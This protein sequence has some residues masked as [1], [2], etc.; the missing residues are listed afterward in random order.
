MAGQ[1][2][3]LAGDLGVR[4]T[5][6]AMRVM[7]QTGP[8]GTGAYLLGHQPSCRDAH[9]VDLWL[10]LLFVPVVPLSRWCVTLTSGDRPELGAVDL[11]VHSRARIPTR[12][13]LLRAVRAVGTAVLASTPLAFSVLEVGSGWA[14]AVLKVLGG[15]LL[16]AEVIGKLGTA[17]E[18]GTMLAGVAAPILLLMRLDERTPRVSLR[19]ALRRRAP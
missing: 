17:W 6:V 8:V 13:A 1:R 5:R 10:C 3:A 16:G 15:G 7:L 11:T 9:E 4:R 2:A 14:T 18:M 12:A 19:S